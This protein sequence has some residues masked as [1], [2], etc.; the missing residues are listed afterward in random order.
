M[1]ICPVPWKPI[2]TKAGCKNTYRVK[3]CEIPNMKSMEDRKKTHKI[4][5]KESLRKRNGRS[6]HV[7]VIAIFTGYINLEVV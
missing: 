4:M 5:Y 2:S 6:V 7:I 3:H 1:E